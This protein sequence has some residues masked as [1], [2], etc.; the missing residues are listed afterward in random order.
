M[1]SKRKKNKRRMRRVQAQRRL[2]EE[3]YAASPPVKASPAL[4]VGAPGTVSKKTAKK[5][6]PVPPKAPEVVSKVPEVVSIVPE[7]V[8]I[9]EVAKVLP[10]V[11]PPKEKPVPVPAPVEIE[12]P[13]EPEPA[14]IKVEVPA[15]PEPEVVVLQQIPV[16]VEIPEVPAPVI[17]E[18]PIVKEEPITI[19]EP[20]ITEEPITIEEPEI[21]EEPTIDASP[22][23]TATIDVA[24]VQEEEEIEEPI[25]PETEPKIEV[26][27]AEVPVATP[28]EIQVVEETAVITEIE[29]THGVCEPEPPVEAQVT[30]FTEEEITVADDNVEEPITE[31][32]E[33]SL[34]SVEETEVVEV[35]T[36]V[37]K[38]EAEIEEVCSQSDEIDQDQ[39][40]DSCSVEVAVDETE[41]VEPELVEPEPT[42]L[43]EVLNVT[44][45]DVEADVEEVSSESEESDEEEEPV[46]VA[47][48]EPK[49]VV[50]EPATEVTE[51]EVVTQV[52]ECVES[53]SVSEEEEEESCSSE[54]EE[55]DCEMEVLPEETPAET[56]QITQDAPIPNGGLSVE[57]DALP[58][59]PL[60]AAPEPVTQIE[61]AP[62]DTADVMVDDFVVTDTS[63]EPTV[64]VCEIFGLGPAKTVPEPELDTSTEEVL[65][66]DAADSLETCPMEEASLTNTS[67][68]MFVET[69][70]IK[71]TP[72]VSSLEI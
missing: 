29:Q 53:G 9:V 17:T 14:P 12:V 50:P 6:K 62:V 43:E 31:Q 72:E 27:A 52:V 63:A 40:V 5:P 32:I 55:D 47:V 56:N 2:L 11:E 51:V 36:I 25:I 4:A 15:E 38:A 71:Q 60:T 64:A 61:E 66:D 22:V 69:E 28:A 44:E 21:L 30:T 23:E 67:V 10:K 39:S 46:E 48:D 19:E 54:E 8:P 68:N 37:T 65:T 1:P 18:E 41:S 26:L 57:P 33:E 70:W 13:A 35:V 16:E 45:P 34:E 59:P 49:C 24:V 7:A 20:V 3:Q 58:L 42:E